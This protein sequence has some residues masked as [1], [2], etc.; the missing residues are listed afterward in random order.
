MPRMRMDAL[1]NILITPH[2][3]CLYF[4]SQQQILSLIRNYLFQVFQIIIH[5][6][7]SILCEK[8]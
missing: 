3:R 5:H 1:L 6:N 4:C 7:C 8:Q 2:Q